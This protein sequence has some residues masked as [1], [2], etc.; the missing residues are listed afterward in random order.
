MST[1]TIKPTASLLAP[2]LARMMRC[3]RRS[4]GVGLSYVRSV[5]GGEAD[6]TGKRTNY[7]GR[8]NDAQGLAAAAWAEILDRDPTYKHR[9]RATDTYNHKVTTRPWRN[10]KTSAWEYLVKAAAD[11]IMGT[12]ARQYLENLARRGFTPPEAP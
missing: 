8:L 12:V 3:S 1:P 11:P 6:P 9:A 2:P 5:I 4:E 7:G 10:G